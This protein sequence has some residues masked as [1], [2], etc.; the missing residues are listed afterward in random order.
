MKA[1]D[2]WRSKQARAARIHPDGVLTQRQ[3]KLLARD[4]PSTEEELAELTDV[5]FV[6]RYGAEIIDVISSALGR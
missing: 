5:V 6:R 2:T 3:M 1:I 4:T